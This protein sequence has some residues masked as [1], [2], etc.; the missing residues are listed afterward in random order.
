VTRIVDTRANDEVFE[1]CRQHFS[2][3]E[4]ADLT[5]VIAAIN[6]WNRLSIGARLIP[7]A[8]HDLTGVP[9]EAGA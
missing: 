6:A 4:M 1:R 7:L 3:R 9:E 5:F 8:A 2:E